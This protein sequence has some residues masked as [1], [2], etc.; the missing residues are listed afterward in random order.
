MRALRIY[1]LPHIFK[2]IELQLVRGE[3]CLHLLIAGYIY[4]IC[5]LLQSSSKYAIIYA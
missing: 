1:P 2:I 5:S 3:Q 4:N